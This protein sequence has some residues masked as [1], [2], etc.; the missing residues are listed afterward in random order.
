MR[1]LKKNSLIKAYLY[2][3]ISA[4]VFLFA[5]FFLG[6]LPFKLA[7]ILVISFWFYSYTKRFTWLCH[8]IL[9]LNIGMAPLSA[10][11]ALNDNITF[12]LVALSMGGSILGRWL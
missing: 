4:A 6:S 10:W 9:G 5:A 12:G 8:F 7:P 3:L 11:I 2:T 1:C